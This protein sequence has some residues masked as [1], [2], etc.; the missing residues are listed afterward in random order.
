MQANK[1]DK[2][3]LFRIRDIIQI[4]TEQ[5]GYIIFI[6]IYSNMFSKEYVS[7]THDS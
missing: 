3:F 5:A 6:Y 2:M 1:I 7:S 4:S